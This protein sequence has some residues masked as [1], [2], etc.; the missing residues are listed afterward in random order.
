MK[1]LGK[2]PS[3]LLFWCVACQSP[4]LTVL[5]SDSIPSDVGKTSNRLAELA[6]TAQQLAG[7]VGDQSNY[8]VPLLRYNLDANKLVSL[9]ICTP[10]PSVY[11]K[12]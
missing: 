7:F 5:P 4:Q 8:R 3:C 9:H 12:E 1:Q 10:V 6:G 11:E 2:V